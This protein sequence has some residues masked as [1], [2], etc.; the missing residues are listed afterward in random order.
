MGITGEQ[1]HERAALWDADNTIFGTNP[2]VADSKQL[3]ANFKDVVKSLRLHFQHKEPKI[4]KAEDI[5]NFNHARVEGKI[6]E[7]RGRMIFNAHMGRV[8][9]P[10]ILD[11]IVASHKQGIDNII[12][13]GRPSVDE[14]VEGT[15]EQCRRTNILPYL[16]D[17]AQGGILF[18][19]AGENTALSKLHAVYETS[20][21]YEM[22]S[23]ADD[24]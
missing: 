18:T 1:L 9:I 14:W 12:N 3:V 5:P 15:I 11:L 2:I 23:M 20:M 21:R 6:T 17:P 22:V 24:Q 10:E 19:P 8:P 4:L 13:T 16:I 7:R